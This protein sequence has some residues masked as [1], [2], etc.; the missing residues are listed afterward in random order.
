MQTKGTRLEGCMTRANGVDEQSPSV[1]A[2]SQYSDSQRLIDDRES[3]FVDALRLKFNTSLP[4]AEPQLS[5]SDAA[6][7]SADLSMRSADA[8]QRFVSCECIECLNSK[9]VNILLD[10][11]KTLVERSQPYKLYVSRLLAKYFS[12]RVDTLATICAIDPRIARMVNKN[13]KTFSSAQ[14]WPDA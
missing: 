11:F 1:I 2:D 10:V 4:Y 3:R 13:K 9:P 12:T 14:I 7:S 6:K 5:F 8:S